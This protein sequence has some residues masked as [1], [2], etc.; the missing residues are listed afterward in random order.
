[1]RKKPFSINNLFCYAAYSVNV[2][3]FENC[4]DS[5]KILKLFFCFTT[6]RVNFHIF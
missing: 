3:F 4:F 5:Y 1:M 6:L 2:K